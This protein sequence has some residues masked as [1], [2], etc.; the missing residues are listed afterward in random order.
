MTQLPYTC[1]MNALVWI[2]QSE[3]EKREEY[4]RN[5]LLTLENNLADICK[6]FEVDISKVKSNV[7]KAELVT[8]RKIFCYVAKIKT[9]G[10]YKSIAAEIGGR[11]HTTSMHHKARVEGY[12][13][14]KDPKFLISWE[15]YLENSSLFNEKDFR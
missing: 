14:V 10:T 13:K 4:R 5:R 7:R 1:S 8:C 3:K 12:L 15:F 9:D 2:A 6:A 11:D